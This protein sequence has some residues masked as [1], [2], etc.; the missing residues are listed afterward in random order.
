MDDPLVP[1]TENLK[2]STARRLFKGKIQSNS[3]A[4]TAVEGTLVI[5]TAAGRAVELYGD[6]KDD[7]EEGEKS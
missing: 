5:A 6:K 4:V 1:E 2:A 3:P 7:G